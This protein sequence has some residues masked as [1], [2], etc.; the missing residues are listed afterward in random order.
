MKTLILSFLVTLYF[1]SLSAQTVVYDD[2]E[3]NKLLVYGVK[4]GMLDSAAKNP[5]PDKINNSEK[6]GKYVRNIEKKFDNIKMSAP[7]KLTDVSSYATYAGNPPQL[8]IKL[9]TDAPP[10]TLVEILLGSKGRNNE[11]PEGTH[12]Q[13]QAYTTKSKAWEELT[14]KFSQVPKG[15]QTSSTEVDQITLLFNPNSSTSHTYY[16]D[17]L[18]GPGM[19][20]EL[21]V[22]PGNAEKK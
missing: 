5:A 7:R 13:F 18:T 2:F 10:G 4:N 8:K 6:C 11:F 9:Y 1:G 17:D 3:G 14:F 22:S 15:S 19:M 20:S 21:V 12:S 16:F